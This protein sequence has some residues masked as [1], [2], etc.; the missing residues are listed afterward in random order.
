MSRVVELFCVV[1]S[2]YQMTG[3]VRESGNL[4]QLHRGSV[5]S[6]FSYLMSKMRGGWTRSS[7]SCLLP[8][9]ILESV[10]NSYLSRKFE[11][12]GVFD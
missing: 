12:N 5:S 10:G 11:L 7:L 2:S 1:E 4:G 9:M 6:G 3:D 8:F